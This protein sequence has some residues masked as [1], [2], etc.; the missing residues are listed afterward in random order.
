[1]REEWTRDNPHGGL[2]GSLFQLLSVPYV[3]DK[4]LHSREWCW[5]LMREKKSFY[6]TMKDIVERMYRCAFHLEYKNQFNYS[7]NQDIF[8]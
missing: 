1:M 3:L 7:K 4:H 5:K 2:L 8:K 6:K